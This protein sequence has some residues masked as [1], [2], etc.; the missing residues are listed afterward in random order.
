MNFLEKVACPRKPSQ[1]I[2]LCYVSVLVCS[3]VVHKP[4]NLCMDN[5]ILDNTT[6]L[7]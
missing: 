6:I 7:K 1:I 5:Y 3:I 2:D 4:Q